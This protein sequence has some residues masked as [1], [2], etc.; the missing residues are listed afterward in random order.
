M[1]ARRGLSRERVLAQAVTLA[2]SRGLDQLS[3]RTLGAA[4]GVH[5]MSLYNHVADK[6]AILDGIVD[7]VVADIA[8]PSSQAS[9]RT[10]MRKRA[11]S[12]HRV[13][14][15]H[16]WSCGL[17]MSRVN[18]GPA[19][20]RYVDATLSCLRSG[21]FGLALADHAWNAMDSY[22][23][24]FTLHK[25]NFPFQP[26][27]YAR[28]AAA[29]L[30]NLSSVEYPSMRALTELVATRQHDGLHD[31]SFGLDLLLDGLERRLSVGS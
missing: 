18:V 20:L 21:G 4:L 9:W 6:E 12:A 13:L 8:L 10:E 30:P 1:T 11:F 19:M 28:V 3:M 25:L 27:E 7:R 15:L 16:P 14:L 22:I 31:L 26:D 2:D 23:Y 17:L 29:Y 5:P 24:G